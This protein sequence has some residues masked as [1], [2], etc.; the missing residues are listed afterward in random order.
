[1]NQSGKSKRPD[2]TIVISVNNEHSTQ[3]KLITVKSTGIDKLLVR[4]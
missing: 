4:L 1:M 3:K 2:E